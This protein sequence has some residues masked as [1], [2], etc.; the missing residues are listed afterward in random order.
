LTTSYRHFSH[1]AGQ[2]GTAVDYR[3][4]ADQS[5]SA[6]FAAGNHQQIA[7]LRQLAFDYDHGSRFHAGALKGMEF[8]AH[9][10]AIWFD[11]SAV[12]VL[13]GS[14]IAYLPQDWM[15]TFSGNAARTAFVNAGASWAPAFSLKLS[16]PVRSRLRADIG[17]GTGAENYSNLDQIGQFSART[18]AAGL[19]YSLNKA[20]QFSVSA[21]YQQRSHELTEINIGGGY[22]LRF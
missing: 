3:I 21:A 10:A 14:A 2:W 18:Y 17:A 12:A 9:S 4:S 22:E 1:S 15:C 16:L 8:V 13:G 6:S 19:H 20:Q 7:P 11:G 5:L